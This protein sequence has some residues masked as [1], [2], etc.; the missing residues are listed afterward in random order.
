MS[1]NNGNVSRSDLTSAP[2]RL[3][4]RLRSGVSQLTRVRRGRTNQ[5]A[6]EECI[7]CCQWE[8]EDT[9]PTRLSA[10]PNR[11]DFSKLELL[12]TTA[13]VFHGDKIGQLGWKGTLEVLFSGTRDKNSPLAALR[14]HEGTIVREIYSYIVNEWAGHVKLTVPAALVRNAHNRH[15][16]KFNHGRQVRNWG[17]TTIIEDARTTSSGFDGFV[18]FARCGRV[19]FPEPAGRNVNMMPFILGDRESLPS[20]I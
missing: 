2:R 10:H 7:R 17:R 20:Y 8:N 1:N 12:P 9:V 11:I 5:A 16:V 14:K 18:A 19:E 15:I 6:S 13:E 3:L 4:N